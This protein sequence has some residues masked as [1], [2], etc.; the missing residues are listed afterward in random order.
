[1]GKRFWI[2]RYLTVFAA[3]FGL[4]AA[5]HLARGRP[6][7]H[8]ATEGLLWAFLTATVF[9]SARLYQSRRGQHCALCRDTP[10]SRS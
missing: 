5:S 3:A 1:M 7:D 9:T 6:I 10:E 8:A 4:I 2:R